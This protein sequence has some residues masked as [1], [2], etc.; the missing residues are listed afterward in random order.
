MSGQV[1]WRNQ[2]A[3]KY[4]LDL[5]TGAAI[6]LAMP[7]RETT[8]TRGRSYSSLTTM[9]H[10]AWTTLELEIGPLDWRNPTNLS[11]RDCFGQLLALTDWLNAG[12]P[13]HVS[14]NTTKSGL[15]PSR[16]SGGTTFETPPEGAGNV[17]LGT[18]KLSIETSPAPA[19]AAGDLV[20]V[21]SERP[22]ADVWASRVASVSGTSPVAV[23][24]TKVNQFTLNGRCW[25]RHVD[26][27]PYMYRQEADL[28]TD[29][30]RWADGASGRVAFWSVRL[31]MMLPEVS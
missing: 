3:I 15:W 16:D 17:Y 4:K 27:Y 10:D 25:I 8:T 9:R 6:A 23:S 20:I 21:E 26:F 24:L 7:G 5:P 22:R 30:F 13:C 19:L 29:P 2:S 12:W 14:L 1:Y 28:N 11:H 31:D 18:E